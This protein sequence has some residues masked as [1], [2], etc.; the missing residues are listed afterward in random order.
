MA[1]I[2]GI[3]GA[4]LD[5]DGTLLDGDHA[6]PG[7]AAA[8]VRLG[9]RGVAYRLITNTTRRPRSAVGDVL[10]RAGIEVRS[11]EILTPAV[12]ARRR[13]LQSEGTRAALMVPA[14]ARQDFEDVPTDYLAPDWVVLGDLG[15]EFDFENINRAFRWLMEGARLLALQKNRYWKTS[16]EG[17]LI[18]A[19][20]FVAGLEFA[21]GVTAEV[22]G[23]P[24]REFFGLALAELGLDAG[25]V[26]MVGDDVTTD[27]RGASDVGCRTAMVRTGKFSEQ[28]MSEEGLTADLVLD[29]VADLLA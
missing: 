26:L 12:L 2:E 6:I 16:E 25:E 20:A 15:R 3:R 18:D 14:A 13:I 24:S 7:A 8:I 17:P 27:G 22:I 5:V 10:R 28:R 29:S 19:G 4:L 11:E 9:Q 23:K 1:W 21:A